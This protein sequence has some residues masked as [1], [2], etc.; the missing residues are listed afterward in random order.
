MLLVRS[1]MDLLPFPFV[2]TSDDGVSPCCTVG[3]AM[4]VYTTFKAIESKDQDAQ[5]SGVPS[6]L[7]WGEATWGDYIANEWGA[8]GSFSLVEV[9]TDKLISWCPMYYHLKFAFLVWLQLPTTSG[10]KQIYANHL[11]PFLSRHQARV[12][13]VLGFAYCEVI[14]LVS[15]YQAEIQFVRSMVVKITGS[16]DQMLRGNA[17]SDNRSPQHSSPEDPASDAETD[18]NHNH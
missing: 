16:A 6:S 17:E 12:D 15:S 4:P 18:Q 5:H 13:Q 14:K 11:R 1:E 8:Y 2:P 7:F 9:F 10:A 3:V